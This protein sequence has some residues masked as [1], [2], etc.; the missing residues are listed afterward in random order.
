M[1]VENWDEIKQYFLESLEEEDI[2]YRSNP[3]FVR[4]NVTKIE[5]RASQIINILRY[6][7]E[8]IGKQVDYNK[9]L[10]IGAGIGGISY[11]IYKYFQAQKLVAADISETNL[12]VVKNVA[13][14]DCQSES[15]TTMYADLNDLSFGDSSYDLIL[16]IDSFH[17]VSNRENCLEKIYRFLNKDGIFFV[18]VVNGIFPLT[19]LVNIPLFTLIPIKKAKEFYTARKRQIAITG[20]R[21]PD[22]FSLAKAMK[23]VGFKDIKTYDKNAKDNGIRRYISFAFSL[24][25]RK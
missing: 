16:T 11:Y 6:Y 1:Q 20:N 21:L 3:R 12:R 4:Y 14:K 22:P 15:V 17:A 2:E 9:I 23:R 7:Q 19:L 18:R 25:G 24:I 10:D 5:D 8:S 13:N